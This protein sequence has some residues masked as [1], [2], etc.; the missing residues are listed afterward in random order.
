MNK[1]S[2]ALAVR[3]PAEAIK[4]IVRRMMA[5]IFPAGKLDKAR[6]QKQYKDF[7]IF[8]AA[9]VAF[10]FFEKKIQ[11]LISVQSADIKALQDQGLVTPPSL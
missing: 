11:S 7:F 1:P 8:L 6:R 3:N 2:S 9:G 4:K 10:Y 5:F